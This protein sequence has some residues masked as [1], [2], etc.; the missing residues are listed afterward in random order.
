MSEL[1]QAAQSELRSSS[2]TGAYERTMQA[3][4]GPQQ[5]TVAT[6]HKIAPTIYYMVKYGTAYQEESVE[7]YE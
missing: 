4:K 1:T 6:A 2:P 5:V 7:V 3:R